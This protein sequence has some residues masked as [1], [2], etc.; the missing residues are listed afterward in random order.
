M[1]STDAVL[2]V[3][4]GRATPE[5]LAAVT[6]V[7]TVLLSAPGPEADSGQAESP[8]WRPGQAR[9]GYRSPYSWQ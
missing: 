2:R 9:G 7:L 6:V 1:S 5:E 8:L 4:R 3:E